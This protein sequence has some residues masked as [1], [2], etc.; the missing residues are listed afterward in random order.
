VDEIERRFLVPE[1]D[2]VP[3]PTASAPIWQ[4]Y[5]AMA[6]E[7]N[8]R[9]RRRGDALT[10]SVKRLPDPGVLVHRIELEIPITEDQLEALRPGVLPEPVEKTRSLVPV[11]DHVAEVDVFAGRLAGLV[12]AEVEFA[13]LAASAAFE[14][15][16]WMGEEITEDRRYLNSEL[17]RHGLPDPGP[18]AT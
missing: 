8:V 2:R 6:A 18:A 11:G 16:D 12:I 3:A 1:P 5:L 4:G 13:S 10:L 14:P 17:A 9:I 7:C 15:P